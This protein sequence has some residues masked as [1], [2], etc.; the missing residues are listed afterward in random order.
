MSSPVAFASWVNET[1]YASR[2]TGNLLTGLGYRYNG[3]D[4]P[5]LVDGRDQYARIF[6]PP[7]HYRMPARSDRYWRRPWQDLSPGHYWDRLED[8]AR[9]GGP[10]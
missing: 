6:G 3:S 2:M 8:R 7:A 10:A 1:V 5:E 9:E 4:R